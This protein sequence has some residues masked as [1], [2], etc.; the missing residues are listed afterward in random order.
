MWRGWL[1]SSNHIFQIRG[2]RGGGPPFTEPALLKAGSGLRPRPAL[3]RCQL[4]WGAQWEPGG[5]L[6]SVQGSPQDPQ[7]EGV[8]TLNLDG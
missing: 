4:R 8:S 1:Q 7:K 3:R 2:K 6:S 5:A